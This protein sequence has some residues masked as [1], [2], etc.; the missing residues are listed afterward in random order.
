MKLAY[1]T[2]YEAK[3]RRNWSGSSYYIAKALSDQNIELIYID[4]L[5]EKF[6]NY[7]LAKQQAYKYFLRKK[8]LRDREPVILRNYAS[9]VE[10]RLKGLEVDAVFSPGTLPIAYLECEKPIVFWTDATFESGLEWPGSERITQKSLIK[11]HLMEKSALDRCALAIYSSDW[12]A[13][14]A[15]EYYKTPPEKVKVVPFGAN[16]EHD[17]TLPNV[18]DMINRRP[19]NLCK[20][21][22][23]G[24]DW[25]RKG[26]AIA[27]AVA[28]ELNKMGLKT[29][30]VI[31]G[32]NPDIKPLPDYV[33]IVGFI[34]KNTIAGREMLNKWFAEAHF[35]IMFSSVEPYGLV[36]CEA[37]SFGV[38]C[39][40]S[41]VGGIPTIIKDGVNGRKFTKSASVSE[42]CSFIS[43]YFSN[44]YQYKE[45]AKS[46]FNEYQMRLNWG[47]AGKQVKDYLVNLLSL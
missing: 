29:E 39:I 24:V 10:V 21:L 33:K 22:F 28:E 16:L 37:N 13:K 34:S 3:D 1:V 31:V 43:D 41:D 17:L 44:Y 42:I 40:A 7:F 18:I 30:F 19:D 15:I 36:F 2:T 5:K 8:L 27:L 11:G 4:G 14:S 23:V 38:P 6:R 32:C 9:Q 45:L 26:G 35:L 47:I 25:F 12:A 46:S 20:L